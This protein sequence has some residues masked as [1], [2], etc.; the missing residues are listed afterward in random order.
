MILAPTRCEKEFLEATQKPLLGKFTP[1]CN[2]D[3]SYHL[4][5]CHTSTGFCWCSHPD[6]TKYP[7]T[8]VRARPDCDKYRSLPDVA[9]L[10]AAFPG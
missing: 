3:G 7:G 4:T 8:E 6:G 9:T 2:P 5:Q 1:R 10:L